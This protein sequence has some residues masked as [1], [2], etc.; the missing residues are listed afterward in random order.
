MIN[1]FIAFLLVAVATLWAS[2]AK[3]DVETVDA[4]GTGFWM[5]RFSTATNY[6]W[7]TKTPLVLVWANTGCGECAKLEEAMS[8]NNF[9]SYMKESFYSYCFVLGKSKKDVG[10]NA[11]SGAQEF[12]RSAAGTLDKKSWISSFPYVCLYWPLADGTFKATCFTGR[13]GTMYVKRWEAMGYTLGD[14]LRESIEKYFADYI[15]VRFATS[16]SEGDRYEADPGFTTNVAVKI[17]ANARPAGLVLAAKYPNGFS[18]FASPV[19]FGE[20]GIAEV[21]VPVPAGIGDEF[22]DKAIDLT[23][24]DAKGVSWATSSITLCRPENGPGN[25]L[26]LD[27]RTAKTLDF[28]EWTCDL[29]V[30]KEKVAATEGDAYIIAS[31]QGSRWCPDC[32]NVDRNFL[33]V[34]NAEGKNVFAEWAKSRQVALVSID[35]P[36]FKG[37][38]TSDHASPSL[39]D[40]TA[41]STTLARA[42]EW[43]ASGADEYLTSPMMRSGTGYLSRKMVDDDTASKLFERNHTI[44][45]SNTDKGGFHRPEDANPNRTG[46]PIFVLLRKDGTVAARLTRMASVSPMANER[47]YIYDYLKRFDEMLAI[48]ATAGDHSDEYEIADNHQSTTPRSLASNGGNAVGELCHAD[49]QDVFRLE[50][51]S[52]GTW[53]KVSVSGSSDA[54]VKATLISVG[55]DGASTTVAAST[56]VLSSGFEV[57]G[58]FPSSAVG[59]YVQIAGSSITSDAFALG[60]AKELNFHQYALTATALLIPSDSEANASAAA[61]ESFVVMRITNGAIYKITGISGGVEGKLEPVGNDL[62]QGLV[63]EDVALETTT[64]G[65]NVSYRVWRPGTISFVDKEVSVFEYD[66]KCEIFVVRSGGSSGA[67]SVAV[68]AI[69]GTTH[70]DRF[71]W[72]DVVLDWADGESGE[73]VVSFVVSPNEIYNEPVSFV[74]GLEGVDGSFA[75]VST[76]TETV[77][78]YD[79]SDPCFAKKSYVVTNFIGFACN[80]ELNVFNVTAEKSL[81]LKKASGSQNLPSGI[82]LKYD[83]STG[84]VVLSG[85]AKKEGEYKTAYSISQGKVAGGASEITIVVRNPVEYNPYLRKARSSQ[86][87][88]LHTD[89]QGASL[90]AG[91]LTVSIS[92]SNKISARYTGTESKTLSFS[93]SWQSLDEATGTASATLV[94]K[95]ALLEISMDA[96]GRVEAWLS[97]PEGY[98]YFDDNSFAAYGEWPGKRNFSSWSGYYTV[99]LPM[100]DAT[101]ADAPSGTAYI[102]LDV[103]SSRAVSS[104]MVKFTGVLPNGKSVSGTTQLVCVGDEAVADVFVRSGE[105]VFGAS[106]LLSPYGKDCWNTPGSVV[107]REVVNPEEGSLAYVLYRQSGNDCLTYHDVC[108]SWYP[109]SLKVGTVIKTFYQDSA[110][111]FAID[112]LGFGRIATGSYNGNKFVLLDAIKGSS[113]SILDKKGTFNGKT[114][115]E[116]DGKTVSGNIKGVLVPG[117][118]D[119]CGCGYVPKELPFGNGLFIYKVKS[120]GRT[121]TSSLPVTIDLDTL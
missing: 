71:E 49:F 101:R 42:R 92:S 16:D 6:A 9:V 93:G 1:R 13:D 96:A 32:A 17:V 10:I 107:A 114:S 52:G 25:P 58:L 94:S 27:E 69:Y 104:G 88:A 106:L 63:D 112:V 24:K 37:P 116:I 30:A 70:D 80:E 38:T 111:P 98:S 7:Q 50:G 46:V 64:E 5:A 43:P 81:K 95:E 99:A 39:F 28:G 51:A 53:Q 73:K 90:V 82:S 100:L 19:E 36:N 33:C 59:C 85:S 79:T 47:D 15:P 74:L 102:T 45:S 108:G 26:Y 4:E 62:Y 117:W 18:D 11:D 23:V 61:G 84:Q 97:L 29:D 91:T 76:G 105:N 34:T 77:Y 113:L 87:L 68:K 109:T 89:S 56:G 44:A 20:D 83:K 40:R 86:I 12:A 2:S 22:L 57:D 21:D 75:E 31:M 110:T 78:I 120:E 48:A 8:D 121:V 67:A 3:C 103:T 60:N 35:I 65:G 41:Y 14:Q 115:I 66:G 118:R 55:S 72:K 54:E 119:D